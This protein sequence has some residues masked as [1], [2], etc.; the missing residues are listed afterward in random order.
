MHFEG[1]RGKA[2]GGGLGGYLF[3]SVVLYFSLVFHSSS[4][5][6]HL[7]AGSERKASSWRLWGNPSVVAAIAHVYILVYSCHDQRW[8]NAI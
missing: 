4:L 7:L 1:G 6:L 8:P 2:W 5:C 3:I